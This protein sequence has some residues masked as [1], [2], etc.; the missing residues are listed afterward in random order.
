LGKKTTG[1]LGYQIIHVITT[2]MRG[3]AE[4][5]LLV[6]VK[7][8][9]NSGYTVRV[10]F[11]KGTLELANELKS[12]GAILEEDIANQPPIIQL[13]KLRRFFKEKTEPK[14]LIHAHL[15][16]AQFLSALAVQKNQTLICTRHDEDPFYP[17]S[18][19]FFSKFLF[20]ILKKKV[21]AWIAISKSVK[22]KMTE[23]G[24]INQSTLI[25]VIYYG[26]ESSIRGENPK[27]KMNAKSSLNI[28][29]DSIVIG[30]VAR[31]VWQKN[32]STLIKS[33]RLILDEYPNSKLL[34]VGDGPLR[35]ELKALCTDL[36]LNESVLFSGKVTDVNAYLRAMDI[37]VL[38]SFTEGFGLVLLEAMNVS[39]PI[40]ASKIPSISEVLNGSGLQFNQGNQFDLRDKIIEILSSNNISIY[41]DASSKRLK[42]FDPKKMWAKTEILYEKALL[43]K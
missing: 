42:D 8:Q 1:S 27:S 21:N 28:S 31:L 3:G 38:P 7:E 6:L 36:S 32:I 12:I 17:G 5:Q 26:L 9:I 40:I 43:N 37:F 4:R 41:S 34:L 15:P 30:C 23:Y 16:R 22:E 33:F 35:S 19:K 2:V 20:C 14:L 13:L 24:E 39:L 25:E 18:R 29:A 11:L 10:I